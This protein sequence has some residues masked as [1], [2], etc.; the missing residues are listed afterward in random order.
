[1]S[2]PQRPLRRPVTQ[3]LYFASLLV[4]GAAL[5]C[6]A[7]EPEQRAPEAAPQPQAPEPRKRNPK[8]VAKPPEVEPPAE[9]KG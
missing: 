7:S 3:R 8:P 5:A 4:L 2:R 9:P 1:M 6:R